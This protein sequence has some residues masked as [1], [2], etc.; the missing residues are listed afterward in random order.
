MSVIAEHE[1]SCPD[2]GL[3]IRVGDRI[4]S[5]STAV[6]RFGDSRALRVDTRWA[7]EVCPTPR[8]TS[9]CPKCF[10]ERPCPCEDEQ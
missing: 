5:E 9:T 8:G 1:G 7:H 2:C 4:V 3:A 10:L 6:V